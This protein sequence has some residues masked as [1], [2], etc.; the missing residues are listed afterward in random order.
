[1]F[2]FGGKFEI[3]RFLQTKFMSKGRNNPQR[4]KIDLPLKFMF[5]KKSTKNYEIFTI[6]L[7]FT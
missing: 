4:L 1:M 2:D 7:T 3:G 6:D 5:S